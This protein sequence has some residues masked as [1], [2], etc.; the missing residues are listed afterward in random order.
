MAEWKILVV[1]DEP[2]GV[3]LMERVLRPLG[4][5]Y[6]ATSVDEAR[7]FIGQIELDAIVTD[8]RMP[9]GSG[10]DLLS[11]VADKSAAIGRVLITGYSDIDATIDAINRGR[12]HAYLS[13]PCPP[14]QLRLTVES[15][16]ERIHLLRENAR[17]LKKLVE[18]HRKLTHATRLL[19]ESQQAAEAA[20][21]AKSAFLS[22]VSDELR[23]PLTTILGYTQ[24]MRRKDASDEERQQGLDAILFSGRHLLSVVNDIL[25]VSRAEAGKLEVTLT[26]FP[27]IQLFDE[28]EVAMG[29]RA[30]L[31]R[32]ELTTCVEPGAEHMVSDP[33]RLRQVL[34]NLIENAL[35]YTETGSVEVCARPAKDSAE[36]ELVVSDT[37]TGMDRAAIPR[38]LQPFRRLHADRNQ[39]GVGLGLTICQRLV[40]ML[41]GRLHIESTPGAGT[42]VSV[43]LPR[44]APAEASTSPAESSGPRDPNGI[45]LHMRVLV[46]EPNV[47]SQRTLSSLLR[48]SGAEVEAT[49]DGLDALERMREAARRGQDFHA[50]LIDSQLRIGDRSSGAALRQE[51]YAG[52]LVALRSRACETLDESID[53]TLSRPVDWLMLVELLAAS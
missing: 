49:A 19:R 12:I 41:R 15:V 52:T 20:H 13:K 26:E 27:M 21:R 50:I 3:E 39:E 29:P 14:S 35:R 2:R 44:E 30:E 33:V 38:A 28:V 24:L 36:I 51:G 10:V 32:L 1:D 31:A 17:L 18:R 5:I 37:G 43:T 7:R 34:C 25:E 9:G 53:A 40:E 11:E 22:N 45:L 8:Q 4:E 46:V 23:T 42:V 6:Q 16:L 47:V 48:Q